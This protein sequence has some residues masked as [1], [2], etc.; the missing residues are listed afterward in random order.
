MPM[1]RGLV[2]TR[3][4]QEWLPRQFLPKCTF[5][6]GIVAMALFCS[7]P[8]SHELRRRRYRL[9]ERFMLYKVTYALWPA[10]LL[11]LGR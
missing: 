1:Q 3:T 2:N 4:G 11:L 10:T 5:S 8:F 6:V 7:M 9:T